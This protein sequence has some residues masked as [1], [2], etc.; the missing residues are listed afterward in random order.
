[1]VSLG[2][3]GSTCSGRSYLPDYLD[4]VPTQRREEIIEKLLR[5]N[6]VEVENLSDFLEIMSIHR[7]T[8]EKPEKTL[9]EYSAPNSAF[10]KQ[11]IEFLNPGV[12]EYRFDGEI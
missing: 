12:R 11:P 3:K 4:R 9:R 10:L 6:K 1:M 5:S 8:P 2:D 7:K